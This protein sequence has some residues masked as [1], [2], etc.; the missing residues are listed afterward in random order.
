MSSKVSVTIKNNSGS[1]Q[2]YVVFAE[3]PTIEPAPEKIQTNVMFSLRGVAG[4]GGQAYF[5]LPSNGLHA[6][7][8]TSDGAAKEELVQFEVLD[9]QPVKPGM[10][11]DN[12]K[13]QP[14]TTCEVM[15]S[16]GTPRFV[17]EHIVPALGGEGTF[18]LRT[19]RDFTYKEAA[20]GSDT[21]HEAV[22]DA[23]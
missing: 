14:G 12:G 10:Q 6:L 16:E 1:T 7:C 3:P 5:T 21:Q 19:R 20:A 4:D 22:R 8:G 15:V 17:D 11:T 13:I 2:T 9:S 23:G 18:C